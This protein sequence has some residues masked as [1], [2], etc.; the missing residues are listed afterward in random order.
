MHLWQFLA[1]QGI[2]FALSSLSFSLTGGGGGSFSDNVAVNSIIFI[3]A[4]WLF[5]VFWRKKLE[6]SSIWNF[7]LSVNLCFNVV[8]YL[9]YFAFHIPA[10]E[11][12]IVLQDFMLVAFLSALGVLMG[13]RTSKPASH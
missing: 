2:L 11:G 13:L 1:T 9:F 6:A 7:V 3:P 5:T 4:S 12:T 8:T 10:P